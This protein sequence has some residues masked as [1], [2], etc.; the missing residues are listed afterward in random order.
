[1]NVERDKRGARKT[2]HFDRYF[3]VIL[4]TLMYREVDKIKLGKKLFP[5]WR[6]ILSQNI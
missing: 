5:N 6:H 2:I 3:S 4:W 1:M